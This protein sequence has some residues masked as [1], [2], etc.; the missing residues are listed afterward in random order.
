MDEMMHR[1][2]SQVR[3]V[4]THTKAQVS[5]AIV[6]GW[7]RT[8]RHV[9]KGSFADALDIDIKTVNR[10]LTGETVPEL[11]TALNSLCVDPTALDEVAALYGVVIRPREIEA[12]N[13]LH[14]IASLSQLVAQFAGALEDGIRKHTETLDLADSIRPLVPI[15]LSI[16]AEADR[17]RGAA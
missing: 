15:L 13:D 10:A 14:T 6:S 16:V 1:T 4:K 17:I 12:A 8:L 7:A 9:G 2:T 5:S 11:H 3:P